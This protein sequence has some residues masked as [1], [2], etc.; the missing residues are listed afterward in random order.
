MDDPQVIIEPLLQQIAELKQTIATLRD[1]NRQLRE[2]LEQQQRVN[3]RQA[4]PFRRRESKKVSEDEK[5]RPNR[6]TIVRNDPC[7]L[8]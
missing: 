7:A 2:Q 5:K 8:R 6:R 4:A 3:A 1:E